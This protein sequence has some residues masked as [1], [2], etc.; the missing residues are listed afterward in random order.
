MYK[1]FRYYQGGFN[2]QSYFVRFTDNKDEILA[3]W[4]FLV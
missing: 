4:E 3:P 2:S 1:V